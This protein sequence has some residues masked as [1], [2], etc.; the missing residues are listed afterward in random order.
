MVA[1]VA[2]GSLVGG[3]GVDLVAISGGRLGLAGGYES[4]WWWC[5]VVC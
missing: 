3:L 2:G 5:G 1:D 4:G